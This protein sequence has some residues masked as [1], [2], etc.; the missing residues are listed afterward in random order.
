MRTGKAKLPESSAVGAQLVGDQQP[1]REALFA[2]QLAHEPECRLPVATALNQHVED[3]TLVVDS[4]PQVHAPAGDPDNHLVEVPSRARARAALPQ[5]AGNQ[6]AEFQHPTPDRLVRDIEAALREHFLNVSVAEG[7]PQIQPNR[8][9]DQ[10]GRETMA[11][12]GQQSHPPTIGY[13]PGRRPSRD[14]AG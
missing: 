3:L 2:E 5:I 10:R 12:V 9:L 4:P 1:R 11:A 13:P 14:N 8:M 7:K 6:R